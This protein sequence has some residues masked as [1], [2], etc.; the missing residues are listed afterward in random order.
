MFENP[1]LNNILSE[2]Q[3]ETTQTNKCLISRLDLYPHNTITLPCNHSYRVDYFIKILRKKPKCPYC[4][5]EVN[6]NIISK[7]C[8][9]LTKKGIVCEKTTYCDSGLCKIHSKPKCTQILKNGKQCSRNQ[10]QGCVTCKL[11]LT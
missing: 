1:L 8:S 4:G 10:I 11:H 6:I 5:T 9:G 7:K 3:K 2:I